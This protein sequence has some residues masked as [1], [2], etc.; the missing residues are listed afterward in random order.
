MSSQLE[1]PTDPASTAA[2]TLKSVFENS[3]QKYKDRTAAVFPDRDLTYE[4]I[5]EESNAVANALVD[6][7]IKR[8]ERI[9]MV[10]GNRSEFP[11]LDVGIMKS[12][13][14][15][16]VINPA[17]TPD[18]FAYM[19]NDAGATT[20]VC[21]SDYVDTFLDLRDS[22]ETVEDY[23]VIQDDE[24]PLPEGFERYSKLLDADSESS[25]DVQPRPG[26]VAAHFYTGGTTGKPKGVPHTHEVMTSMIYSHVL[27][28]EISAGDDLLLVTPLTHSALAFLWTSLFVGGRCVIRDDFAPKRMLVDI[29]KYGITW[30]FMVPTMVYTVLDHP[31]LHEHDT[32]SLNTIC[33][34]AAPMTS[35]RLEEG[36]DAFGPVFIQFYG[37][38]EVPNLITS[39]PKAEHQQALEADKTERLSSAGTPCIM[40]DVKIV[41]VESGEPVDRGEDGEIL[42]TAPYRME[43]YH[44][45][46]EKTE[47]T[48][49]EG[50]VHTGD[51][52]KID[53]DGYVYL[54]DRKSDMIITGGM[55]VYST[56]VEEALASHPAVQEVAVIGV[57]HETW[58][59]AVKGVVTLQENEDAS[60]DELIDHANERLADYKKPKSIDFQ[61]ELP[62]TSLGKIDKKV[63]RE[64][65]W[66]DEERNI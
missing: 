9:A 14:A 46:P 28:M 7:G 12:G 10:M 24:E 16:V 45:L 52:G 42:A 40:S 64:P 58:G 63:L 53:E 39:F 29:E 26:D 65:Y 6:R 41:D 49:D 4:A 22:L 62:K 23:Y 55:N 54:L 33:Y 11:G 36:I 38:T 31:E 1:A 5:E 44:N 19:I 59:E 25:P 43:G 61:E 47:E 3:L 56:E 30:T 27:E 51:I 18:D 34:G 21:E 15:K 60:E 32:K 50:Y 35:A 48:I 66:E 8:E 2:Y 17:L 57:P 20:V 37:Q 13:A